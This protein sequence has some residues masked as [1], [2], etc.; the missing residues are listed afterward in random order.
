M[1]LQ[2]ESRDPAITSIP[3]I[4]VALIVKNQNLCRDT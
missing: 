2:V 4:Q 3:D 1:S